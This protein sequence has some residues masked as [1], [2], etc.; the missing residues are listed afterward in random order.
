MNE[1]KIERKKTLKELEDECAR[2][3][4]AEKKWEDT[5]RK[6]SIE[7][8][9]NAANLSAYRSKISTLKK[10]ANQGNKNAAKQRGKDVVN[11]T[12]LNLLTIAQLAPL[13]GCSAKTVR[14]MHNAGRLPTPFKLPG[15]S[16]WKWR[17]QDIINYLDK[18]S[19]SSTKEI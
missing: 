7:I 4:E 18:L 13:L 3:V 19:G 15:S 9:R 8:G 5:I 10:Q 17:E 1:K 12:R 6:I 16:V 11:S 14:R 2:M